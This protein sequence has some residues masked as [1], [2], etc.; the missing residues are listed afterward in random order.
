[1]AAA[2][3]DSNAWYVV[4]NA[5]LGKVGDPIT[6][7]L[8]D[9]SVGPRVFACKHGDVNQTMLWQFQ[10]LKSKAGRYVMRLKN[11]G[12]RE[13]FSVC[14]ETDEVHSAKT[15]GCLR[16]STSDETQ[17]WD[18]A[19]WG[20]GMYDLA[21]VA[22]GTGYRLDVHP[23]SNSFMNDMFEGKEGVNGPQIAQ[24]WIMTS[25]APVNNKALSTII[26]AQVTHPFTPFMLLYVLKVRSL[27]RRLLSR[28]RPEKQRQ[29]GCLR[30]LPLALG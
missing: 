15:V 6:A 24:R 18:V 10:P 7:C 12:L 22:N 5:R 16:T 28:T 19:D 4:T 2:E 8:Q 11:T 14:W 21:N 3:L 26:F 23:G 1:M 9:T 25:H 20:D 27:R 30:E 29:G 17:Q 13:Q